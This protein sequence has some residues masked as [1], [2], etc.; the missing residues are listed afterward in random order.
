MT[1][2]SFERFIADLVRDLPA[3]SR[4]VL[5]ANIATY[6]RAF[7]VDD[8]EVFEQIG[9]TAI[10][11]FIINY[12]Y[13]LFPHLNTKDGV[14]VVARIRIKYTSSAFLAGLADDLG[15]W[16]HIV[17]TEDAVTATRRQA[18]LEDVFEAFIGATG[19]IIDRA[20]G[21]GSGFIVCCSLL[22]AI[23]DTVY[24]DI[25]YESLFDPKTRLKELC[26]F[27]KHRLGIAWGSDK[28]HDGTIKAMLWYTLDGVKQVAYATA[29]TKVD[30]EQAAA[31]EV[32]AV[33]NARGIKKDLPEIFA[34]RGSTDPRQSKR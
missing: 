28:L 19:Y 10:S 9:D 22:N 13:R 3:T 16:P 20:F 30:A 34:C 24:I 27:F 18:V 5:L 4:D 1:T 26:D 23:Y 7:T 14:K 8:Y 21:L 31:N 25:S 32:I 2:D 15:F 6:K 29:R 12:S 33:L 11:Q 17:G